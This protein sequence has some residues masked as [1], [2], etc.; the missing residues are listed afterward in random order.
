MYTTCAEF[1]FTLCETNNY[2]KVSITIRKAIKE[3]LPDVLDLVKEL[4][5]HV[6]HLD[7]VK[8]K[9]EDYELAF[10]EHLIKVL[11]AHNELEECVGMC[12][13]YLN[14]STWNGKML[15]LEDFVVKK[16]YRRD[17]VGQLLFDAFLDL[18]REE[19]CKMVKWQLYE[20][21][22]VALNFYKKNNAIIEG[23][24]LN[25]KLYL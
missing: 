24:W 21:N 5:L 22:E 6:D 4:A 23:E 1:D 25:A 19:K 12:F 11:V 17:G 20:W 2:K 14:F 15:Y 13:G 3:D 8:A 18:A 16:D 9:I 7:A 10:D